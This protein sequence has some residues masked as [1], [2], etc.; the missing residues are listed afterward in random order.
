MLNRRALFV[1][2][3]AVP[4]ATPSIATAQATRT[5][6]FVPRFGLTALDP[7]LTTDQVT[8]TMGLMVFESLYS[9][10]ESLAPR[11]QMAEGQLVEDGGRR[12]T[13]RLRDGLRFHDNTPVL[14]RDC[15]AS[16]RRWMARDLTARAM[17]PAVDAIEAPDDRTVMFRLRRPFPRLDFVLGK[18]LGNVLAIM[19]ARLAETDPAK[20]VAELVGSGPFRFLP[21]AFQAGSR[22]AFARFDGYR[23][24]EDAPSGGAG[25]RVARVERVEWIAQPDPATAAAALRTGEVD[26][27]DAPLPDLVPS[28]RTRGVVVDHFDPFG[29][30]AML[31][32]NHLQGPTAN[33][34]VR[35]AIMAAIDPTEVMQAVAGDP[36][37]FTAPVGVFTPNS[38]SDSRAGMELIGPRSPDTVRALLREAGYGGERM[39]MLHATDNIFA[40]AACQVIAARLRAAGMAIDDAATDQGTVVQ[41][42]ASK[43]PLDKGG[44]SMFPQ[45]PNAADHLD[46]MVALGLRT[47]EAAWIGWPQNARMEE[48]RTA[49]IDA[50]DED[51]RRSLA[52]EIQ[53]EALE[54]VAYAPL[55]RYLQPSAWRAGVT[56]IL[57]SPLPLFWNIEKRT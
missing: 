24:R 47:G 4:L 54:D 11:P 3:L 26:W 56:G 55:G 22:A 13:I 20:P 37:M 30:Y 49:W 31:R 45:N 41:R 18:P 39:V 23:P 6:R 2:A 1:S 48:L 35:Q 32:L 27:V 5:L 53:R 43:A 40:H 46:P 51:R 38:P 10:D 7:I 9:T 57:S 36:A 42:R 16:I 25:G 33:R 34:A 17:A 29:V 44:W 15:V 19:P 50:A 8:R 28:L 12:W 21:E 14:A 52:A